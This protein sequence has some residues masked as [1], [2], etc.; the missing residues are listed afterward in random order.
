M[1]VRPGSVVVDVEIA[2][3]SSD[4][5]DAVSAAIVNPDALRMVPEF[6]KRTLPFSF[7]SSWC[8]HVCHQARSFLES[9]SLP[10]PPAHLLQVS[11]LALAATDAAGELPA[12][13]ALICRCKVSLKYRRCR[14]TASCLPGTVSGADPP[15]LCTGSD[16]TWNDRGCYVEVTAARKCQCSVLNHVMCRDLGAAC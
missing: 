10:H 15:S 2:S 4:I 7:S 13:P 1:A 11:P 5:A 14:L 16:W 3:S 6:G 12:Q 8:H 9:S